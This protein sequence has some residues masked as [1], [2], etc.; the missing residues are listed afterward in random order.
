MNLASTLQWSGFQV[1]GICI[2]A[3]FALAMAAF[4][5]LVITALWQNYGP[6][7]MCRRPETLIVLSTYRR[8]ER[9]GE[10]KCFKTA[11][12]MQIARLIGVAWRFRWFVGVLT[13]KKDDGE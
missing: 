13:F 11:E 9:T 3:I 1:I 5:A 6:T 4:M 8:D 12:D 2:T 10:G 7:F